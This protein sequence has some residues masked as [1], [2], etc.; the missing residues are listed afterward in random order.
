[1][2]TLATSERDAVCVRETWPAVAE[3]NGNGCRMFEARSFLISSAVLFLVLVKDCW[4]K[5][6]NRF[7][8]WSHILSH[9]FDSIMH[10]VFAEVRMNLSKR[11]TTQPTYR[12]IELIIIHFARL[13][14]QFLKLLE[15]FPIFVTCVPMIPFLASDTC[16]VVNIAE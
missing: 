3:E 12:V 1:M 4:R 6:S 16:P 10:S 9:S 14:T 7:S 13:V 11:A 8:N 5:T 15:N 2:W